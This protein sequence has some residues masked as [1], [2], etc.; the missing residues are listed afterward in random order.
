M[1]AVKRK[2]CGLSFVIC[3]GCLIGW[4]APVVYADPPLARP[5]VT[6]FSTPYIELNKVAGQLG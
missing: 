2:S 6:L 4:C 1:N 5:D 3:L